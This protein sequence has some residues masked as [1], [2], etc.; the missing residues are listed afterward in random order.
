[1]LNT[2]LRDLYVLNHL[3]LKIISRAK[4]Y[5]YFPPCTH[6]ETKAKRG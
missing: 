5:S 3:I 4:Q 1:M 6:E 2:F